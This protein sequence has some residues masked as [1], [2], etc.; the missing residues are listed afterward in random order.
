MCK[1]EAVVSQGN[2]EEIRVEFKKVFQQSA[3]PLLLLSVDAA[4]PTPYTHRFK[5]AVLS[6]GKF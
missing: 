1:G 6:L 5:M 3:L 4:L 2:C